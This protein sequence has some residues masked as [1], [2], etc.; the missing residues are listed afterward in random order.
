TTFSQTYY[1]TVHTWTGYLVAIIAAV[2]QQ[3]LAVKYPGFT[4]GRQY[5]WFQSGL[6]SQDLQ[7]GLRCH[8]RGPGDLFWPVYYWNWCSR[9]RRWARTG[10]DRL[11]P[12]CLAR[13][14]LGQSGFAHHV[15]FNSPSGFYSPTNSLNHAFL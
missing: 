4:L 14:H 5:Y 8:R 7:S 1:S 10:A 6:T 13:G 15:I 2:V 9:F 12:Y 11:A 3:C